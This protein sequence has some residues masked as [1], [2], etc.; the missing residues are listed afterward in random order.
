MV[1][2]PVFLTA[3]IALAALVSG[4]TYLKCDCSPTKRGFS[5]SVL[6]LLVEDVNEVVEKAKEEK[7]KG[8]TSAQVE[9][10]EVSKAAKR[11]R[12]CVKNHSHEECVNADAALRRGKCYPNC[13]TFCAFYEPTWE[14]INLKGERAPACNTVPDYRS[15]K[16]QIVAGKADHESAIRPTPSPSRKPVVAP[17]A[18][19]QD[20]DKDADNEAAESEGSASTLESSPE[21][22]PSTPSTIETRPVNEGC[23]AVEHL[24][25]YVMQHRRH[26]EREVFCAHGFCATPNHAI[27]VDSEWTSMKRLCAEKWAC[28]KS[29]KL[30]NN[31]KLTANSRAVFNDFI[32]ITPYD[33]RFPRWGVWLV[34]HAEDLY[35]SVGVAALVGSLVATLLAAVVV[36]KRV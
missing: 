3:I 10:F 31:L 16:P 9:Q 4:R 21:P 23:V 5:E 8:A 6:K 20:A 34:Q 14:N 26:L 13:R 30:V 25:G 2:T 18:E 24:E 29:V 22:S 19:D 36:S 27:I 33:L 1:R 7:E 32:T 11:F 28:V 35:E 15:D 12:N 17:G